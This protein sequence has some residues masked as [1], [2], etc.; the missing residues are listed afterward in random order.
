MRSAQS[1]FE[2]HAYGVLL[3]GEFIA[4]NVR[5]CNERVCSKSLWTWAGRDNLKCLSVG[6]LKV[7]RS[8]GRPSICGEPLSLQ[9]VKDVGV[10][11]VVDDVK[12]DRP[13]ENGDCLACKGTRTDGWMGWME[14][15][16]DG[17]A[18]ATVTDPPIDR[19]TD[20]SR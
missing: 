16:I 17:W 7:G 19:P 3:G 12:R 14:R 5:Y 20:L 13:E 6:Q 11:I 2:I 4:M 8:V 15:W 1:I 18:T 9:C 10:N